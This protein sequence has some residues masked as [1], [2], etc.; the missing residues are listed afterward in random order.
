MVRKKDGGWRP[1]GYYRRLNND[2]IP[3]CNHCR[4]Y[5]LFGRFLSF[6]QIGSPELPGS[7]VCFWHPEACHHHS[8]W[9]AWVPQAFFWLEK[10]RP[11]IPK[12]DG[13]DFWRPPF[14]FCLCG[15]HFCFLQEHQFPCFS[16]AR[17]FWALPAT[18]AT[19]C[20]FAVS[21]IEFLGHW[22]S[23]SSC[24]PLSKHT[25]VIKDFPVPSDKPGLQRFLGLLNFYRKIMKNAAVVLAPLTNALKGPGKSL[26]WSEQFFHQ[27]QTT[28]PCSAIFSSP[29]SSSPNF[30]CCWCHQ[31]S[32]WS[33]PST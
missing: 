28:S 19:K 27:G 11:K 22:V 25:D 5:F 21:E 7:Y 24:T 4:F 1:G 26:V 29:C 18:W 15:W 9:Y 30:P 32:H 33:S 14:L 10:C 20:E 8:L 23:A 31:H 12:N 13:A 17:C 2:T 3:D 6:F 16:P